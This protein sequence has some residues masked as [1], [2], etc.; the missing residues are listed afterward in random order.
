LALS[1]E[2]IQEG[3][4]EILLPTVYCCFLLANAYLLSVSPYLLAAPYVAVGLALLYRYAYLLPSRHRKLL[5]GSLEKASTGLEE[6]GTITHDNVDVAWRNMNLNL[7]LTQVRRAPISASVTTHRRQSKRLTQT[8]FGTIHESDS[9]ADLM[10][11][12]VDLDDENEDGGHLNGLEFP[13]SIENMRVHPTRYKNFKY[14]EKYRNKAATHYVNKHIW[15]SES[16]VPRESV[17]AFELTNLEEFFDSRPDITRRDSQRITDQESPRGAALS[18]SHLSFSSH[19][20]SASSHRL[21]SVSSPRLSGVSYTSGSR[22]QSHSSRFYQ[23]RLTSRASTG[24]SDGQD[25]AV[26]SFHNDDLDTVSSL[27]QPH[28]P[29]SSA[30]DENSLSQ[31][32]GVSVA[33]LSPRR[34]K[35]LTARDVWKSKDQHF[36]S[37]F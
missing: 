36:S 3:V 35:K 24:Y 26:H 27:P 23:E 10:C 5:A 25:S 14:R 20:P 21:S 7:N 18:S 9:A 13:Q 28:S 16:K 15:H 31:M 8:F 33:S 19:R 2:T 29:S 17:K 30:H 4:M 1:H 6:R 12:S 34:Q 32:R 37:K 11:G 22:R